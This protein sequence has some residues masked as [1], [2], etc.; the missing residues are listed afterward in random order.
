MI[1]ITGLDH[2]QLAMPEGA[3]EQARSFYRDLLGL[4]EVE[5]PAPLQPRGGCWFEG[6]GVIIHM[7]VEQEFRPA[8]KAHPA[9][10]VGDLEAAREA[11]AASGVQLT[12]DETLAEVRRFYAADPFGNRIEFIQEGDGFSQR[13][14][15]PTL[16]S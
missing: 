15:D 7:G 6:D 8:R 4:R 12:P 11:L 2:I 13:W 3:E 1:V 10:L 14:I 16:P 5:K 9:L